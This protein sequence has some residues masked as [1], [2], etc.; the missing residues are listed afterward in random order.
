[1]RTS[2]RMSVDVATV[3]SEIFI[4][5]DQCLR[6]MQEKKT[7]FEHGIQRISFYSTYKTTWGV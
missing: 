6:A 7:Y 2:A 5:I 4:Q 3:V 1:M